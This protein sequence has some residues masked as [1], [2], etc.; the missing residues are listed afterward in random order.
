MLLE[1]PE[2]RFQLD[3]ELDHRLQEIYGPRVNIVL[4]AMQAMPSRY[5]FRINTLKTERDVVIQSMIADGLRA[6]PHKQLKDAG[7]LHPRPSKIETDGNIVEADRI[8]A[9][10]VQL[11]AHLY[12]PGVK[13]CH[14]L[15]PGMKVTVVDETGTPVGS[16]VS[17]QSE[18]SVLT[19]RQ[20]VAVEI[21]IS[22][23]GLPSIMETPWYANGQIH[24]Q[25]LPA[26]LTSH[27]LGPKPGETIV[28]LN[29]APGG[30]TSHICQIT[31]NQARIIGFDRNKQ[32]IRNAEELMNR[33][34]CANYQL[35]SHDSRYVHL[36]YNIKADRVLVDPPCTALGVIPKLAIETT[37]RNVENSADYQK[38]F[39]TAASRIT[40]N[41]GTVVYSVCT[42]S[43]EECE[44]VVGFAEKELGLELQEQTP[45]LAEAGFDPD[46]LT[47]RF[48]PDFHET[49]YFIARFIKN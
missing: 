10:A 31:R 47:Q 42:I 2:R 30:K 45:F 36:D 49:G 44:D 40:K 5:Y 22:R 18:T 1:L 21:K 26:I 27:V 48:N 43:K 20:G 17:H 14:G 32:K 3:P 28:D 25:S 19:Y 29:C 37:M 15:R 16:G 12:A 38:Q 7:F 6:E 33:M 23:T 41:G 24:L 46:H 4:S 9:E 11:G 13:R 39:L 35:I 8:A 34:G